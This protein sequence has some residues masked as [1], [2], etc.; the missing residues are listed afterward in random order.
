MIDCKVCHRKFITIN[1]MHLAT[2]EINAIQ[3]KKKFKVKYIHS[4]QTR[5]KIRLFNLS[6]EKRKTTVSPYERQ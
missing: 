2:H 6:F 1:S 5:K 4:R 3:Y